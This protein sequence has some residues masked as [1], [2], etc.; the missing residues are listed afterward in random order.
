MNAMKKLIICIALVINSC[1]GEL[2]LE[3][4][5]EVCLKLQIEENNLYNYALLDDIDYK[6]SEIK[7]DKIIKN[8]KICDS[9]SKEYFTYLEKIE[10]DVLRKG[11]VIFFENYF[12][13]L[14]G[15]NY[16]KRARKFKSEMGKFTNSTNLIKRLNL[17]FGMNDVKGE[18]NLYI[19]YLDNYFRGFP[20]IQSSAFVNSKKRK[21]L[22]FENEL[23]TEIITSKK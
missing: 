17:V 4:K 22:E 15:K 13:S 9:L 3:K 19:R 23:I 20:K 10:K 2:S 7:N 6:I 12:Y 14:E 8:V 1:D 11:N 21:V 5:Y 16:E 18:N